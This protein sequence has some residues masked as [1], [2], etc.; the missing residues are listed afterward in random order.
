MLSIIGIA[1]G[2]TTIRRCLNI[3][4]ASA[5]GVGKTGITVTAE[6]RPR[7]PGVCSGKDTAFT[8]SATAPTATVTS[9]RAKVIGCKEDIISIAATSI[10]TAAIGNFSQFL[11]SKINFGNG[12]FK[13]RS[14]FVA[15]FF[16]RQIRKKK[17]NFMARQNLKNL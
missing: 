10:E 1:V 5:I 17:L 4:T 16:S 7:K 9:A 2:K 3:K 15:R 6:L 13:D 8:T 14:F 12:F 11:S